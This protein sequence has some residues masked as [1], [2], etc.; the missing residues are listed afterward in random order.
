[1]SD[2]ELADKIYQYLPDFLEKEED[3][4]MF[5]F[6]AAH[7]EEMEEYEQD[8]NAIT[9]SRQVDNAEGEELDE[10]GRLFGTIGLRRG[11]SDSAYRSYIKSIVPIFSGRGTKY[12]VR[13]AISAALSIPTEDFSIEENFTTVSYAIYIHKWT[14]HDLNGIRDIAQIADP[15]GV[16]LTDV[17]YGPVNEEVSAT[18]T[19]TY[20]VGELFEEPPVLGSDTV[21]QGDKR[22][23]TEQQISNDEIQIVEFDAAWD[24]SSWG[25]MRWT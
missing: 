2:R 9:L 14:G 16:E 4:V 19:V 17:I 6:I 8:I 20:D 3:S 10:L 21:S 18:D 12:D 15:S 24:V 13:R 23:F 7:G 22:T 1:M 5:R 25:D 11:R